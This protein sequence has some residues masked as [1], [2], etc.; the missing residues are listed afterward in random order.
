MEKSK[1]AQH[2]LENKYSIDSMDDIMEA[3]HVNRKGELMIILERFYI[4]GET[5]L[6]NQ[7]NDN[8]RVK[9]NIIFDTIIQNSTE[10]GQLS[11][12]PL[13]SP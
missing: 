6:E 10:R 3:L 11:P 4:Y 2:P 5:K 13:V 7:I 12:Q 9:S 1:F 8:C